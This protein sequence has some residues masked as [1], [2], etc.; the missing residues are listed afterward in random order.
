MSRK[1]QPLT[2]QQIYKRNVRKSRTYKRLAPIS[3]WLFMIIFI[4]FTLAAFRNSVG[5]ITEIIQLLD[6]DVYN[7]VEIAENYQMLKEKY[8]EWT[9]IGGEGSIGEIRF[10]NIEKAIIGGLTITYITTAVV[11]LFLA[12]FLGKQ[13]FPKLS[14]YYENVIIDTDRLTQLDIKAE[15]DELKKKKEWF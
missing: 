8:G 9:I 14:Q 11:S 6:K 10:I 12:L 4:I 15:L 7:R 1:K 2:P 5:N 13:L 3:Y